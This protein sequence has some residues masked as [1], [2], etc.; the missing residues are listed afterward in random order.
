M[1]AHSQ[2]RA[3]SSNESDSREKRCAKRRRA[4]EFRR[5]L[6]FVGIG[7]AIFLLWR[8]VAVLWAFEGY[9][10]AMGALPHDHPMHRVIET[11]IFLT[12]AI[13]PV[14]IYGVLR[15]RSRRKK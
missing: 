7:I 14:V 10:G 13:V 11:A 12:I 2:A 4:E 5:V 6:A 8:V 3:D 9:A 1:P 15:L